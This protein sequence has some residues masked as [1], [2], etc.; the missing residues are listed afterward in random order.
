M[1]GWL[2]ERQVYVYMYVRFLVAPARGNITLE[3]LVGWHD[4]V[5]CLFNLLLQ[6]TY[7]KDACGEESSCIA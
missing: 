5:N 3:C 2:V 4:V 7:Y 6:V 1:S